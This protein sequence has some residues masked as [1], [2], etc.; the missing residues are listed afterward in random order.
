LKSKKHEQKKARK[1]LK[2]AKKQQKK[3]A[4]QR[5]AS[6]IVSHIDTEETQTAE[7]GTMLLKT[8][9]VK[10]VGTAAW[11]EETIA[12]F[13]KG[14]EAVVAA[15]CR[16]V[17]VGAVAPEEVVYIRTMFQVPTAPGK[18]K[19][20][21]RLNNPEAGRFGSPMKSF[22]IVEEPESEPIEDEKIAAEVEEVYEEPA[23][24]AEPQPEPF[25]FQTACDQIVAMGFS[26]ENTKSILVAVEGNVERALEILMQ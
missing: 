1:E 23:A 25:R 17:Q 14:R 6:E 3:V 5:F 19:V 20:I 12:S 26:E 15:D 10:N 4:K 24:P 7:P 9:K 13:V 8:W 22:I 11:S 21:F 18:Y 2:K 16:L